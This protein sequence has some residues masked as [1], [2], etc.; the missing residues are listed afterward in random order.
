MAQ[1]WDWTDQVMRTAEQVLPLSEG[2][3]ASLW[4]EYS[5]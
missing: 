5:P 2:L 1:R 3:D 4:V